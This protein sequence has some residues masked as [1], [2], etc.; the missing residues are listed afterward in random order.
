VEPL[1]AIERQNDRL[2]HLVTD[3]LW[4]ARTDQSRTPVPFQPCCLNDLLADLV[5]ELAPMAQ[6]ADV[7]IYTCDLNSRLYVLGNEEQLY[8]LFSNLIVN[9]I[10]Y[11]PAGGQ[12]TIDLR[13][14]HSAVIVEVEDTGIG[15]ATSDQKKIFDRFYRADASRARHTGGTGLGLAICLA[16]VRLHKGTIQ[17]KSQPGDGSRFTIA[18]PRYTSAEL[19]VCHNFR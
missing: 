17:V 10:Q 19:M 16:I 7:E 8:R 11:T 18:L 4:L 14:T 2:T 5:E 9:G 3:L 12:V 1:E 6:L 15:I 13:P